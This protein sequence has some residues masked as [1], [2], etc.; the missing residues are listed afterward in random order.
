MLNGTLRI[1][2]LP[3]WQGR[4]WK[5]WHGK[6][7]LFNDL[8]IEETLCCESTKVPS[9]R[10]EIHFLLNYFIN[11]SITWNRIHAIAV[12]YDLCV[13][14]TFI[15]VS[16]TAGRSDA[17]TNGKAWRLLAAIALLLPDYCCGG[18][19][20]LSDVY[21]RLY[22]SLVTLNYKAITVIWRVTFVT[23]LHTISISISI[24]G[25]GSWAVWGMNCLRSL[26]SRD[27]LVR[28]PHKAWTFGLCMCLFCVRVVLYLGRGLATSW[29]LVQGV[30][31]SVKMIMKL[32]KQRPGLK[33]AVETV[34][35]LVLVVVVVIIFNHRISQLKRKS[36]IFIFGR[37]PARTSNILNDILVFHDFPQSLQYI[38]IYHSL[39]TDNNSCVRHSVII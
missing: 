18:K 26:G 3:F 24:A 28:I 4:I 13:V 29:S 22:S 20:G 30:L 12:E 38:E 32:K 2:F 37:F 21:A 36:F 10:N 39:V 5:R 25:H 6:G 34:K 1:I 23:N 27:R 14:K 19:Q 9:L 8:L 17:S 7:Y 31:P 35:K 11:Y 33:G 16:V 15:G